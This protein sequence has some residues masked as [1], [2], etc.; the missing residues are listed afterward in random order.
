MNGTIFA[1]E[2]FLDRLQATSRHV[3]SETKTKPRISNKTVDFAKTIKNKPTQY[4]IG[5]R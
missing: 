2:V 1:C 3:Q 4:I 5:C